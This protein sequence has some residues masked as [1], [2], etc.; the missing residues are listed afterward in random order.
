LLVDNLRVGNSARTYSV[1][2]LR[3]RLLSDAALAAL[4]RTVD[5]SSKADSV[6]LVDP[7]WDPGAR[8]AIGR[9]GEA[10]S[11]SFTQPADLE[12]LL[13]TSAV[14]SY[15][16]TV[17]REAK[18]SPLGR[19]QLDVASDVVANAGL[20]SSIISRSERVDISLA[21][22][23]AGM[24]GIRW[25]L[26]RPT[27]IAIAAARERQTR[28]ELAKIS[29][30]APPSVTLSSSKGGFPLT[31]R[32]DTDEEIRIG[33]DLESSN[34]ALTIPGVTPVEVGAGE[35]RTLTVQVDLGAQRTTDLTAHLQ[36]T[37]G[38]TL[39]KATTFRVRSSSISAVLWVAMGLAGVFVLGAL[40]RRFHRHRTGR[41]SEPLA[42]DDD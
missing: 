24:L 1:A 21:R 40:V 20:L 27:G 14:S 39:G 36:T 5:S 4:E 28:A 11:A 37:E 7:T 41:S 8:W 33:V 35:R 13:T 18:A 19:S 10:F 16:G 3:Q 34:P 31:I 42:D 32:N 38:Q 12:S 30:E 17:P 25:R 26:D 23:V 2:T 6:I 9:L 22:S 29:I 15:E